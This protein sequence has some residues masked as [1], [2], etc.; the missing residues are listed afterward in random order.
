MSADKPFEAVL[1][2][3]DG[4]L[5]DSVGELADSM[6]AVLS[7][8]GLPQHAVADYKLFVGAGAA[9][10]VERALPVA[11]R[12][13]P[14]IEQCLAELVA[15]YRERWHLSVLYDGIAE[16]LDALT[17]RSTPMI[18]LSNKPD[19]FTNLIAGRCLA[20]WR[21]AAVRGALPDV[22]RK[23]D[24]TSALQLAEQLAVAPAD[25]AYLGDTGIDMETARRA[26]MYGIGVLWGFRGRQELIDH[27]ARALI[28]RPAELLSLARFA[29]DDTTR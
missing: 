7:A 17:A 24:P 23:P 28:A 2:D 6:N 5:L 9:Q 16:L 22:P 12:D 25:I 29:R 13:P 27:G 21:F 18:I 10:L 1:F 20:R 4:T 8:R 3:L 15:A 19:D 11:L 26:G 14:T